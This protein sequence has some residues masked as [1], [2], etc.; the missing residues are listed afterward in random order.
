[1][2]DRIKAQRPPNGGAS[3][4]R[5][6]D[7]R[8]PAPAERRGGGRGAQRDDI[9]KIS[10]TL[11]SKLDNER[12]ERKKLEE[13]L[14]LLDTASKPN[15]DMAV[16]AGDDDDDLA[17]AVVA[18]RDKL[19]HAKAMPECMH[20]LLGESYEAVITRLQEELAKAQ[21]AVRASNPTGKRL[22][23]A[24][25][26]KIRMVKKLDDAKA[27]QVESDAAVLAAQ[28]LAEQRKAAT[29]EAEA[30]VAKA[31]QEVADLAALLA[32]EKASGQAAAPGPPSNDPTAA[33]PPPPG[34]VS[35]AFAEKA[36]QDRELGFAKQ[37]K[38][39]Q[40]LLDHHASGPSVQDG[41]ASVASDLGNVEELDDEAWTKVAKSRRAALLRR[42][43]D[44]LASKV[45]SKLGGGV[46]SVRSPFKKQRADHE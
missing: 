36:W 4:R 14:A 28:K 18:A 39:L 16:D 38:D 9:D 8:T 11:Q 5:Q 32:S 7:N 2:L 43:S 3:A 37:L 42:S 17:K 46:A 33:A 12:R 25:A 13:R 24:E 45:R 27:A 15:T 23:G 44:A 41:S 20:N 35:I 40:D 1:V 6:P 21:A 30:A 26:Y 29:A 22:E 10:K 31:T 19:K 34:C